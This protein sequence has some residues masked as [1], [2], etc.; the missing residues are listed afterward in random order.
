MHG[1]SLASTLV[2]GGLKFI[3]SKLNTGKLQDGLK[4]VGSKLFNVGQKALTSA[5]AALA[6]NTTKIQEAA[7][8]SASD[9][10]KEK[11]A[12]LVDDL[13]KSGSVSEA[14]SEVRKHVETLPQ[15]VK[16]VSNV[17]LTTGKA[18][19]RTAVKAARKQAAK[20]I[21]ADSGLSANHASILSNLMAGSGAPREPRS[22]RIGS[23]IKF[24]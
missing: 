17:A 22:A 9:F 24:V 20:S 2:Q 6:E 18:A 5:G 13:K 19:A 10:V 14:V 1:G 3:K 8:K 16:K 21:A 15:E 7:V 11:T 4:W 12:A 23:G